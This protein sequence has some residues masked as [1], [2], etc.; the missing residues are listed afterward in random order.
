VQRRTRTL[1]ITGTSGG[2]VRSVNVT[3]TIQ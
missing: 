1:T 2:L 3:L